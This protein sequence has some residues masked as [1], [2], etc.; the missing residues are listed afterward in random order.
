[1]ALLRPVPRYPGCIA[2]VVILLTVWLLLLR[3]PNPAK[4]THGLALETLLLIPITGACSH[5]SFADT[6]NLYH[7]LA[8]FSMPQLRSVID[9]SPVGK[10]AYL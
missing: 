1:M 7:A 8:L 6:F 10:P 5:A 9:F 2:L 3:D 4:K